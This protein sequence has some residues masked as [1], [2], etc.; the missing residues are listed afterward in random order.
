MD[1]V[2]YMCDKC[3][4][5]A[6][7]RVNNAPETLQCKK[8]G[9]TVH[10]IRDDKLSEL[11]TELKPYGITVSWIGYACA[12]FDEKGKCHIK[13][14]MLKYS[15]I[16]ID[17]YFTNA[18]INIMDPQ[19]Y[20][21]SAQKDKSKLEVSVEYIGA[22]ID[23]D[24]IKGID[25]YAEILSIRKYFYGTIIKAVNLL[26]FSNRSNPR[27]KAYAGDQVIRDT[28]KAYWCE[29]C[30]NIGYISITSRPILHTEIEFDSSV[31]VTD[32]IVE[33][34][35]LC[36]EC[37]SYMVELD[38]DISDRIKK[39]NDMGIRTMYCCQGHYRKTNQLVFP[40]TLNGYSS[41]NYV[42]H[43]YIQFIIKNDT[44]LRIMDM[45]E[46]LKKSDKYNDIYTE[47]YTE[48]E[49]V[50]FIIR[51]YMPDIDEDIFNSRY[52]QFMQFIDEF[53]EMYRVGIG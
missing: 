52:N 1:F 28:K 31:E 35:V 3:E 24:N 43:P 10:A 30:G 36:K 45:I 51:V 5:I 13:Y 12:S 7:R 14:P 44:L 19:K 11:D 53:I 42:D 20:S 21:I 39:L 2:Y 18:L 25:V 40:K 32:P 26:K 4:H 29:E 27:G 47:V 15:D 41:L 37:D 22:R 49:G 9:T 6:H 34:H 8:C 23:S 16:H 48:N 38:Y 33:Y 17:S 50:V 46:E